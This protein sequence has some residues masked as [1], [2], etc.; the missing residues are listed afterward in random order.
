MQAHRSHHT[1]RMRPA[2]TGCVNDGKAE[3]SALQPAVDRGA[4]SRLI[5]NNPSGPDSHLF[6]EHCDH[7]PVIHRLHPGICCG[8]RSDIGYIH[9][10]R[11]FVQIFRVHERN[12]RQFKPQFCRPKSFFH[13]AAS[14]SAEYAAAQHGGLQMFHCQIQFC[15]CILLV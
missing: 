15:H 1:G 4:S 9:K 8:R 13:G 11:I 6:T 7:A 3:E 12:R 14:A 10:N 2:V 5:C